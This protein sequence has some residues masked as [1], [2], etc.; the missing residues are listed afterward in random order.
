MIT[1]CVTFYGV[2]R[3]A[4]AVIRDVISAIPW[5]ELAVN[6]DVKAYL[7]TRDRNRTHDAGLSSSPALPF[8]MIFITQLIH[9]SVKERLLDTLSLHDW[10][11]AGLFGEPSRWC[12]SRAF[13][14]FS[15]SLSREMHFLLARLVQ[16]R[17]DGSRRGGS[18]ISPDSR[19]ISAYRAV[20]SYT[21]LTHVDRLCQKTDFS[22]QIYACLSNIAINDEYNKS[23]LV[24]KILH[25]KACFFKI[26][27]T[28]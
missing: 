3:D 19:R 10:R 18:A 22:L 2:V 5:R 12:V 21:W 16:H 15:L 1:I 6:T 4:Y 11:R 14:I 28:L 26:N 27:F 9:R 7:S 20:W 13:T 24:I 25:T 8:Y 17:E 23:P